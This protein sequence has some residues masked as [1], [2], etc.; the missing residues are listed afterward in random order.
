[1]RSIRFPNGSSVPNVHSVNEQS[2]TGAA[3]LG[4]RLP[5]LLPD[6]LDGAQRA[7]HTR[8]R[9]TRLRTAEEAGYLAALPDGRLIGPFNA[10]L[11]SPTLAQPL[12]EWAEAIARANI[13]ADVRE[14]VILTVAA[15]WGAEYALYAHTAGAGYAGV[16]E[17][18]IAALRHGDTPL[19]LRAEAD[20]AHRLAIALVRDHQVPDDL[21]ADAVT[22]FGIDG[23]VALVNL[24]GQYLNTS[25]LLACFQVP[26]PIA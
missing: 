9:N 6:A 22:A 15:E 23:L 19:G 20:I 5:L 12:L 3:E 24:V 17:T 8:L 10:M 26:A 13:P 4:G 21:Y 11:R 7:V 18:A 1:M 25:A 16:P 14:V 2:T